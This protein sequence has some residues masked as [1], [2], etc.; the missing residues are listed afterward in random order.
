[1]KTVVGISKTE[2]DFKSASFEQEIE[3]KT[4]AVDRAQK[5]IDDAQTDVTVK[6][7]EFDASLKKYEEEQKQKAQEDEIFM[8]LEIAV[9]VGL[10]LFEGPG[11]L[12]SGAGKLSKAA[13]RAK[14][15]QSAIKKTQRLK[16]IGELCG[17]FEKVHAVKGVVKDFYQ[18]WKHPQ[19]KNTSDPD[20]IKGRLKTCMQEVRGTDGFDWGEMKMMWDDF[21]IDN[22]A[23]FKEMD[24]DIPNKEDYRNALKKLCCRGRDLMVAQK[25]A[26]DLRREAAKAVAYQQ[27]LESK[28]A[29]YVLDPQTKIK[30][31]QPLALAKA[32]LQQELDSARRSLFLAIHRWFLIWAYQNGR[33][34]LPKAKRPQIDDTT[35]NF[36][37]EIATLEGEMATSALTGAYFRTLPLLPRYF[38]GHQWE[39]Y[40]T[41][42]LEIA[43][44]NSGIINRL[45]VD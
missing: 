39:D 24:F 31:A 7:R 23:T 2:A 41:V 17:K 27:L 34:S 25:E 15:I 28:K 42:V 33:S 16:N 3:D 6:M 35:S 44:T 9:D 21:E 1:M 8:W 14:N 26:Q 29:E 12:I 20:D 11:P 38:F 5:R 45:A 32:I 13:K 30:T 4:A 37:A 43:N 36:V 10:C 40:N 19:A 22:E 18:A